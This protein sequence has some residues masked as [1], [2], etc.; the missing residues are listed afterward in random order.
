[1]QSVA[2]EY[3]PN[4]P[5]MIR[6][7]WERF[8][9]RTVLRYTDDEDR[10]HDL[11][12]AEAQALVNAVAKGFIAKGVEPGQTVSIMA[13]TRYEWSIV[14]V[15]LWTA[16]ALPV[17][18]YDTSSASQID[19]ITSDAEVAMIVVETPYHAE[20]ARTV[21]ADPESPLEHILV[22]DEGAIDDLV[23]AGKGIADAELHR[24]AALAGHDDLATIIY[25]SGTTG[26]PKGVEL[27]HFNYVR[28]TV[29]IQQELAPVLLSEGASTVLFMTLAHSLAR[30][31]EVVLLAS[32][33][34]IG[35]CPDSKKLVPLL[36]TFKPTLLLAVPRVFEK[37]Y[38]S[39]EQKA[40]AGGKVKIFRWAA[41]QAIEYSKAKGT[42]RGPSAMLKVTHGIAYK[43]VLSKIVE[44]LGGNARWAISGSAPLGD[45]LGHF[46][47]GLGLHV[48]EGYGLTEVNAASH[49]NRPDVTKIGTVGKVLPGMEAKEAEDG[50]ILMRGDM[51]FR[52]YHRNPE[53]TKAAM[54]D[55][56]FATGDIG[57]I[58]DEGFLT[59]TGRKKEIIVT[60]GGKNV[61]PAVLED[62][63]RAYPL[64]DQCVVVGDGKPFIAALVTLDA[65][66]LPGWLKGKELPEMTIA[67][68]AEHPVVREHLDRAIE[69]A[70]KAVSR[71]ESIRKYEIL[72]DEFS[73]DNGYLTPSLKV[74]RAQVL[75]DY[76]QRIEDLYTSRKA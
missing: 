68:A 51:L 37:V 67:E 13:R 38:N 1:M 6:D 76:A 53:A 4:I 55:G 3:A 71:A 27:T 60:A 48:M 54:V 49:V 26:R 64:V 25:T 72:L 65:E 43:L 32:G 36:G 28:H 33:T 41:K 61:A 24:R 19:W 21:A 2:Q 5:L 12:G 31:V 52:G 7:A 69:R 39:A 66:A 35:Y 16:G 34:V 9:D 57:T 10:W 22:M 59:I 44:V 75:S 20:L 11:T 15:A 46:Y 42:P 17:P 29:G 45:R 40:A 74:K 18:I 70:N 14:D 62:R 63:L 30:L 56:W 73:V 58:D 8:A 50:E 23:A 47:G